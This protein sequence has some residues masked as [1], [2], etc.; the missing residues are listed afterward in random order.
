[1][2]GTRGIN[3]GKKN[4]QWKGTGVGYSALHHWVKRHK[5]KNEICEKCKT[6][7]SIDLANISGKYKRDLSDWEWL[8]RSCHMN[9]D[10]RIN[11]L[12]RVAKQDNYITCIVCNNKRR[13]INFQIKRGD[14]LKYCSYH[15]FR[16]DREKNKK[17]TEQIKKDRHEYYLRHKSGKENFS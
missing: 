7:S 9:S 12:K 6:R 16:I 3:L 13:V 1:M 5:P 2:S 4:G 10:G 15:C 14:A 8:C 17:T 11:N